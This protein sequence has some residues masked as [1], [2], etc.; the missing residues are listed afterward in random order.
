MKTTAVT[1]ADLSASVIAVPP[2]ARHA[3]LSI[4]PKANRALIQHLEDG[5][6]RT[7][8]Y[9]GNANFYHLPTSEY[10]ATLDFLA[11]A[12]GKDTW[13]IPSAGADYGKLMDQAALLRLRAFPTAMALPFGNPS[14]DSGVATA[15]R[16][17][18]DK[19]G[20]PVIAYVKAMG[21]IE[22]RTLG[23]LVR[24]GVVCAIK[25]AIVREDSAKDAYLDDLL[26]HVPA[27]LVVSGIGE[28]PA[29]VHWRKFGLRAFTSGS[30]CVGPRGSTRILQLLKAQRYDDAEKVRAAYIALEDQRDARGPIRVL[31]D[32][33]TLAGIADMGPILPMVANLEAAER[34]AVQAAA[35]AL[36]AHDRALA[37][38]KVA[39]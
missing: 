12:A 35:S 38:E 1:P 36:L 34:P 21:Y 8:M 20:K 15:L 37:A 14:N 9:G 30:V 7:L 18:A 33:V 25:Y 3:D 23:L 28:R 11:E 32:A 6:V 16:R 5:G 4:D 24:D 22:P 27:E 29:L 10:A 17:F 26:T 2:L 13:V 39:A 31:H 19:L